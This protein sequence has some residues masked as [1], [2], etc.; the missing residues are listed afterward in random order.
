MRLCPEKGSAELFYFVA[1]DPSVTLGKIGRACSLKSGQTKYARMLRGRAT[2]C[3]RTLVHVRCFFEFPS[4]SR[5]SKKQSQL[6][7]F[8]AWYIPK[9]RFIIGPRSNSV[10]CKDLLSYLQSV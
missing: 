4:T 1:L 2:V 8:F 6:G 3:H 5:Q 10:L 9:N 7:A